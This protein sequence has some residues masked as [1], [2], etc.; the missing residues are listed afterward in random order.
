MIP[1]KQYLH[2]AGLTA[3]LVLALSC[4]CQR[5]TR[6]EANALPGYLEADLI[7]IACPTA[8]YLETLSVQR[9]QQVDKN[10][11]LF[12][13]DTSQLDHNL[14]AAKAKHVAAEQRATDAGRG[15]REENIRRLQANLTA[16]QAA[17]AFARA[18][19]TRNHELA[20]TSAVSQSVADLS[21]S[22]MKQSA[23]QVRALEAELELARQGQ[24][25]LQIESLTS[26]ASALEASE[27]DATWLRA[28]AARIAPEAAIVQDTLFEPGEW[29][30]AGRPVVVLRRITDLRARFYISP[31]YASSLKTGDRVEVML[32]GS[33]SPLSATVTRISDQAEYTPP[34]IYSREESQRLLFLVEARLQP[35]D[36]ARLHPGLPVTIKI[37]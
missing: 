9:G 16:A 8:G 1:M 2:P 20:K 35:A 33:T 34:V 24:R 25:P 22:Q 15:E 26:E 7:E 23:E 36:A 11:P 28:Q 5:D 31:Q 6:S 27:R 12:R 13:I 4:G 29:I 21:E 37:P 3:C 18:E 19:Y 30:A 17:Q 10:A 14:E 32:P